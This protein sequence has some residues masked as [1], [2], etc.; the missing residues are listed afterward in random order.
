MQ[1]WVK[2][3]VVGAALCG[4]PC[5]WLR[6]PN[7]GRPRRAAPTMISVTPCVACLYSDPTTR[8][9]RWSYPACVPRMLPLPDSMPA[10]DRNPHALGPVFVHQISCQSSV[11]VPL[12]ILFPPFHLVCGQI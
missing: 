3:E 9:D 2:N 4:R 5:F 11:I 10:T 8:P 6:A 1:R 12:L 7:K